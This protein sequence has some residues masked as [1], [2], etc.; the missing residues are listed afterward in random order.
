[1]WRRNKKS[2]VFTHFLTQKSTHLSTHVLRSVDLWIKGSA[3]SRTF[4]LRC[5]ASSL[6]LSGASHGLFYPEIPPPQYYCEFFKL[7]LVSRQSII[8]RMTSRS[9]SGR[10]RNVGDAHNHQDRQTSVRDC[11]SKASPDPKE[12][13]GRVMG[14]ISQKSP[15]PKTSTERLHRM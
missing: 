14:S 13:F 11:K 2:L 15:P 3:K 8:N 7:I 5:D 4:L 10:A 1:M 12:K 6:P 9:G